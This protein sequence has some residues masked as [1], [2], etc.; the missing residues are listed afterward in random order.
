MGPSISLHCRAHAE[1][2]CFK[3]Y[4]DSSASPV[5]QSLITTAKSSIP[6]LPLSEREWNIDNW[7]LQGFA[8]LEHDCPVVGVVQSTSKPVPEWAMSLHKAASTPLPLPVCQEQQQGHR[9]E[10]G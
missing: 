4:N 7:L 10:L 8:G 9:D 2:P 6:P 1:G 5:E 3:L